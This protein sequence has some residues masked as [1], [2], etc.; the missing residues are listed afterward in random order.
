MTVDGMKIPGFIDLDQLV[1]SVG[2]DNTV[3]ICS[4]LSEK[5][6]TSSSSLHGEERC[7]GWH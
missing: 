7:D 1:S 2:T 6:V 3:T 5:I 4:E